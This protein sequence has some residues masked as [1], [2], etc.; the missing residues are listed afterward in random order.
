MAGGDYV[1]PGRKGNGACSSATDHQT[2]VN[3]RFSNIYYAN[4]GYYGIDARHLQSTTRPGAGTSWDAQ[5]RSRSECSRRVAYAA[6]KRRRKRQPAGPVHVGG[7]RCCSSRTA[8]GRRQSDV[9]TRDHP[10]VS[11][12]SEPG[13]G[14]QSRPRATLPALPATFAPQDSRPRSGRLTSSSRISKSVENNSRYWSAGESVKVGVGP[15]P[16]RSQVIPRSG[17]PRA[18]GAVGTPGRVEGVPFRDRVKML[19]RMRASPPGRSHRAIC[20]TKRASELGATCS[21]RP[22]R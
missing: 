3:N 10:P 1:I 17:R 14:E 13:L 7:S 6:V 9:H 5:P 2:V 11:G 16:A 18:A 12:R 21:K 20:G 15:I 4:G 8:R 22:P 19:G